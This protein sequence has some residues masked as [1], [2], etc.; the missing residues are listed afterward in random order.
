[1]A[2]RTTT[3]AGA[4]ALIVAVGG[5]AA[6]QAPPAPAQAPPPPAQAPPPPAQAPPAPAPTID[7]EAVAA[8]NRMGAF[9]RQQRTLLIKAETTTDEVLASGQKIQLGETIDLRVRRPNRLRA[10]VE[11]DRKSR[12]F[13]YDGKTFTLFGPRAGYYAS[14]AAPPTIDEFLEMVAQRHGLEFPLVDLFYWGTPKSG[15]SDIRTAS[16][17]GRSSVAG[18]PCD[19]YAFRQADIDWQIWIERSTNPVPR[20]LVI[21]STREPGQPQHTVVMNWTLSPLL[22]DELFAFVPS[23]SAQRI[24]L[25]TVGEASRARQGRQPAGPSPRRGTP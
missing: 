23:R 20:K 18:T 13:F 25:A 17:L 8:L 2:I 4:L 7:Q 19:H 9:L 14:V 12:R 15:I 16:S 1:M 3:A 24:Q 22:E 21:T 5:I 6:A 11:S 10:D